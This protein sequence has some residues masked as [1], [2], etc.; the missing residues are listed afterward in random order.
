MTQ[1]APGKHQRKGL[2]LL[3][4][5]D[6]FSDE[7]KAR[8]WIEEQ[9]WPDGPYCPHCGSDNV[10]VG[11]NHK[12]MTHRCRDCPNK[13]MFTVRIGSVM[14]SSKLSYRVWAVGIYLFTTS[15]KGVS[16]MKLHRELGIGQKAAWFMLHRL[17]E[18]Y[19]TKTPIFDGP[20]EAD[21]T[22]MGGKEKNK[23][24]KKK[25]RAGRGAVGK[26]AVSG[27]RDRA[28]GKVHA[29]VVERTDAETLQGFVTDHTADG[30]QV[31][32]DEA[33][34]YKG[35]DRPHEAVNHSAGEYVRDMAHTNG[36]ESFWAPMKRGV[37]GVYHKM[38]PKH[39][40]RYVD[41]FSGRHNNR[42]KDTIDQMGSLVSGM[43]G[44]RLRYVDLIADN[45]LSS[46][47]KPIT[48]N[49]A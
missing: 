1:K 17:R 45:G 34:A 20:V 28:T 36:L 41:E 12:S 46:G 26:S 21:E 6:M 33:K 13:P 40:Q 7:T 3:Q 8:E 2:T 37:D 15:L 39:L 25:L 42:P 5:A 48:R 4:I 31:Y 32:T 19:A 16:S 30:A 44:K 14:Q 29:K 38:S 27:V 22:Y 35:I 18:A 49:G 23:H 11:V 24:A 10:R 47:A 9:R 43:D